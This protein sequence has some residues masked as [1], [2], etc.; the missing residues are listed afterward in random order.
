MPNHFMKLWKRGLALLLAGV[1]LFSNLSGSLAFAESTPSQETTETT[2]ETAETADTVSLSEQAQAFVDAVAALDRDSMVAASNDW[3]LA[4]Q[5]WMADLDNA[6]LESKLNEAIAV[7]E[8]TCAPLYAAEDLYNQIPEAER[9]DDRVQDAYAVWAA[10][11]AA[12]Y[13]AMENPVATG[14]GG[15][16]DLAEITEMLYDD[17]P[18]EPTGSY[19]GSMG[20]P[21]ATGQTRISISEWVT[22]LYDG[23]D[24]HINAEALHA[25]DLVITVDREPGE[26]YAIV[27]LMVQVEYPANGST[28]EILLPEDVV[29]LDFE[30]N[31]A[32]ADEIAFITKAS[33]TETS[34]SASGFYVKAK[35]DFSVEFVYHGSDGSELRKT[36]QVKLG[37][38]KV[39]AKAAANAG[40]GTYAAGP[41]PPFTTGKITSISFEGGTWLIWFNGIEAYCCSH[42]LNGQPNGCPTYN[43]SYV[44][45]LEPGQYTP[46]NHYA[47]QVNIWGGLGQL[48][49]NLLEEKH[50]GTSASTYG[51]ES[52]SAEAAAYRYYDDVQLW[53]MANYPNSLAA[54]TYRASAQALAEQG[55]ENRA[56][57]Y[58]GENG[59]YTYI[60][61][62]PA[63]YA[64]QIVAIVGEEISE[65][66]GTD[67]PDVPDTEYYSANWTA[68]AQSASGSFDLTFTANADKQ[69]LETGEKVDGA[70]ITVT[71]SKTSG[72]IDGGSWQ[73]S[74]A[75]AQ[76]ITT[77]GHTNDDNY[78][79][80]GGDGTVS[81]TVHYEVSKTST[82]TLSGQEGPFSSQAEAD[83]AAEAA[84]NAAISQ[85]KNE[86][87]GM[88]DAAIAAARAELATIRFSYD[89]VEIPYG[90]E[91]FNGSLG[92]HQTITVPAD[93]S[94]DYV[95][96]N[97]EWSLQ[98]NLKKV[99]SE[100]GEQITGDALYE[101]Y[102]WDTVT[103]QYI[104]F[105]GYNQ[106]TVVRNEDGTYSVANGTDYGTE[107]DTSRKM[108]YT[109]RN[110][111]KFIIVETRAP[112]GYYGDWTDVEHP[113]TAG[114][115]L[116]KRGYYIEITRA[117]DGSVITLDN[118]HYS[119]DI[120]N[121]Y[122]GGTKLLTSGG[123]ET[124]VTIYKASDE[125]AA[126]IQY[127]DAGRVYNTDNS[128]TAANEDSYTMTPVTGVMQND[129]SLGEISIS[130]VDLDAVRYVGGRDTNGDAM[131]SGQ[132]H[133]D[134][135]LDG[136]VYDLYAAED[137]QHPDGVTGT[138][139]YSK[140]TY[141]DGTPI[142]HTTIRDNSGQWVDDYLPVL[143]KDHLVASAV[144]KDGWL[145]FSNLY[146]GK[147]YIVERGT[148]VV[149][150]VER[151]AYK[152]SGTYPDVDAKTKE[153]TGTTSPLATNGQG[154]YTDYVYKHQWSYIG[155]SKALDGTKTYDGYYESY[156]TGYLCDEHNYYIT[157][158]YADE[159]WYIEKT[160]FEDNRQAEGEQLDTTTYS[161]NYHLHRDNELAESQDQVMKGN[162]ELSKHVSSTGSSDGIDLEGAGFTFY[163]I[164]DLSKE[165][166]F[167]QSRS[168]KYLI[169]SILDAYINPE[170]DESHPKYDFSGEAQA[171]AKTYEVNADQIAA[172]N[173][174]LTAAGDFKNGSGDGWVAMGRPNAYQLAEIFS[175]DTGTI[176]VQGLPYG[177]YLV[178]E[179]TTPKDVFQAEPFIVTI[180][181]TDE[182][183]P[184]SAM[185]NPKDAVQT[186][187]GSYQKY[188]VLDEEI[189]VYLRV[190]KIDEETGKAVLLK[191]T[192]FQIYWMDEQGNHIYDE[193]GNAKLVTMTDTTNPLLPKDVDT[194]YTDDT[195][196]LVLPEKLPLG[197]YRL[198]EVNGP[199]GYFNEWVASAVYEDGHLQI[200]DTG[201]FADGSF[202]VDF[203]VTTERVYKATGD[204]SEDS[205]D[206]LV[207]D[208]DYQNN[209]TLG[210]L[211]I[212]KTGEVLTGWQEDEGGTFDPE[213]SGEARP[214]HFVYEERPIPYA[215][216]TITANEDI[217]TQDRQTDANGNRTLWY[218][219]GDVVAVVCT[220]DGTSDIAAFAPGRTNSTYDFLSVIHD[221]TV[222]E[223]TVTLPLGS[224]HIEETGAPYGFVGT[225][226]SYDVTFVWDK[227]TN[228]VVLA[229]TVTSNPGDGSASETENYEI[230][231]VKDASDAQ[232]EAQVLKFHNER[233]K[234]QLDIYKRDIKTGA[235]V[236]G[237]VYNLITVDD[238]YSATGDLLF[239]AGDLIATSA[240]TDEN[241]HTTFTCDFPMR[242]EFYGMEGVRIPENTTANSGKYR[243]VELRPPQ[244]YYLDAPDQVF[245]FVYQ[246]A[247]T[248]VIE[249]ENTFENDATSFFVSKRKLTGDE[250]LPGAT[251]TIQDKDGNVVRQWVSGDTPTE[252]RGLE[253]DTVYTLVETASPN[254]YE[255]AESIRFKLVQR[256]DENGDL[257]NES[258]VYVC[259]GKDWLIFDHWTLLEDGMVVMRDAPSP[260]TPENPSPTPTPKPEQPVSTPVPTPKPVASLPQTGDNTPLGLLVALAGAAGIAF[261]ILLYKRRHTEEPSPED[262]PQYE[263][264]T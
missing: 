37:E 204:D 237:A 192:A 199:N 115:P 98:V 264:R 69:Q 85:L 17:L 160:A 95:M 179:T 57:T 178:V 3:G 207:I 193:N 15:E 120:A 78:Q 62:P 121:S 47:N 252:I 46:G 216:Y 81:W 239:R 48:S 31:P 258:D 104:P 184:Q 12:T 249:M 116:G 244:G 89:E 189:E 86:A 52:E 247:E 135:R 83:A 241:G 59:Y 105:G 186:P 133:A 161:A 149:I 63:G 171:I 36:L 188:T 23:V 64:W 197:H 28:S 9:S 114:T 187:S 101:V 137:I 139:D 200:D 158:S 72:S 103:Q 146:L 77:S 255:L 55:T 100:T 5:A 125:P 208:E 41:T 82:T 73:M 97:D 140:I 67:I 195:G 7:Q 157:P 13:A 166:Q 212:R 49:L 93:S 111:G 168:G 152:L 263:E 245:E 18:D 10:I 130:K 159:G 145:T 22:D 229:K 126:E 223:V 220:G 148:G 50:S 215:E 253:F 108:Y 136:A 173:A 226:Q 40:A 127:Q 76:T 70:K 170:Y 246:G 132:A 210:V 25:D 236:A 222:G 80:N 182:S 201:N 51:L 129:R 191:D 14:A 90:F 39:A 61:N 110:E 211:K 56:A 155:Q 183:N 224:Y 240:P 203:S 123:V 30:G 144:I 234:P 53:I 141:D 2:A 214:G 92:S 232:I 202:Y 87:Q 205:Q 45:K 177:Q 4:H 94:N 194:F 248:S 26:E 96:K 153:P 180:D 243:I 71:P 60:Y 24:A 88:V 261:G 238:I 21:I 112:S 32:D 35:Q 65:G 251:L 107:Y 27:P 165:D 58:S 218:A 142:W 113:G 134:A 228:D 151:G 34:A 118:T 131:A 42:G 198:V 109:Q 29:L 102:E 175:N 181:P 209:E 138:V 174:T 256:K 262:D 8:E 1:L 68:P 16:P 219:K 164:S 66:G 230:V 185:A 43:F 122:T 213:F 33:Y 250:E 143:A 217:Y 11:L 163:L 257:L 254:G 124:T 260:D 74:P 119:A 79:N 225:K 106:Y 221:G 150:P 6:V 147:Y 231:N 84:K 44:S 227:Q 167:A 176:R 259:T 38:C 91:E 169:K 196:M 117:N 75:G 172:Y 190:T 128:G 99:D 206:I 242:G 54:Q 19:I 235:L 154:Q 156:A 233:V 162:V 20:L